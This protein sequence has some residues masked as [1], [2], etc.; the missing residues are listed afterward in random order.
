MKYYDRQTVKTSVNVVSQQFV[1]QSSC[2]TPK[3]DYTLQC[4][5]FTNFP[6]NILIGK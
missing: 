4:S 1:H 2:V 3:A 6:K 5:H